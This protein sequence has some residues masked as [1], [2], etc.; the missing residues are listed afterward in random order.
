MLPGVEANYGE[1][2][3][4]AIQIPADYLPPGAKVFCRTPAGVDAELML[5]W[6]DSY[7][8]DN[9]ELRRAGKTILAFDGYASHL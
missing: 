3:G 6:V 5:S 7:L 8:A 1:L 4:G 2:L 9:V